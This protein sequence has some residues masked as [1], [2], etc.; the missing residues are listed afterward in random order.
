[1]IK[2]ISFNEY[3][4]F[5]GYTLN[6]LT[7]FT[8][9]LG[10]NNSGKTAILDYVYEMAPHDTNYIAMEELIFLYSDKAV[11]VPKNIQRLRKKALQDLLSTFENLSD[12]LQKEIFTHFKY[13]TNIEIDY[14]RGAVNHFLERKGDK[15]Y[16]LDLYEIGGAYITLFATLVYSLE[17]DNSYILIDEPELSLHASM[18][19]KLFRVLK[20]ISK[21][22]GKQVFIATHS[23]LFLDKD[24]PKNNFKIKTDHVND[25]KVISQINNA[26][27]M[28]I[29]TYQL[30]GNSPSDIMMPSNFIIVEG[31]SDK[32][33]LVKLMQRFYREK[34][35]NKNIIVQPSSGDITNKQIP[36]TLAAIEKLYSIL[37][38]N[39][40]YKN[41]AVIL[42]DTQDKKILKQFK[43][44]YDI[45]A[46]R[47]R[48]LGEI[49][50]YALEESYPHD[51]L[52]RLIKKYKAK[53]RQPR[54]LVRSILRNK[55]NKKIEWAKR[56]GD[57]IRFEEVPKIF[58]EII[59][60]AIDLAV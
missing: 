32:I 44:K 53:P 60:T 5:Y 9:F 46:Q 59:E 4:P 11:K 45:P 48:S 34:I 1:M 57:E 2:K 20:K 12:D 47:L 28:Y 8:V 21:K 50:K 26:Q 22:K 51:V 35:G 41:K 13:L 54:E 40:M 6:G 15:V 38:S 3:S 52:A 27:D 56:V 19:K 36:K 58:K 42:V 43:S 33:F 55:G 14:H 7:S 17:N 31:P 24:R 18:Q 29:A 23:Q 49:N 39:S 16:H 30:L 37:D 25:H 10:Q